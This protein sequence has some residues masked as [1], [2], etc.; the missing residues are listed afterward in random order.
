[1]NLFKILHITSFLTLQQNIA[2]WQTSEQSTYDI[3]MCLKELCKMAMES[4]N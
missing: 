1:M 4:E 2:K 3:I